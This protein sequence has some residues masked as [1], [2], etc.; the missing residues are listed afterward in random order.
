MIGRSA[1]RHGRGHA[2]RG[3]NDS[4]T[5]VRARLAFAGA[6]LACFGAIST[7]ASA[8]PVL[9]DRIDGTVERA[10]LVLEITTTLRTPLV[11]ARRPP[12]LVASYEPS[13]LASA[14]HDAGGY[15]AS[16]VHVTEHGAPLTPRVLS[17]TID[18]PLDAGVSDLDVERL[19]E[20]V[21]IAYALPEG[22]TDLALEVSSTVLDEYEYAPG[23]R[24]DETFAVT[25][26]SS[27]SR[28]ASGVVHRDKPFAATL[29]RVGVS[30]VDGRK[31]YGIAV[32]AF[33]VIVA[34]LGSRRMGRR[35]RR[36]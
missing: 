8:H 17:A 2:Q 22:S 36:R 3:A 5:A 6:L 21:R 16:H 7:R 24:W 27:N 14:V 26:S 18:D 33:V 32:A 29:P 23:Q 9:L 34:L 19:H 20:R 12:S 15:F 31:W 25:L 4:T 35:M 11:I 10:D 1:G 28:T 30:K 13:E